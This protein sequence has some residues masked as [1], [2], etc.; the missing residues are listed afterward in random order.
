M[1]MKLAEHRLKNLNESTYHGDMMRQVYDKYRQPAPASVIQAIVNFLTV[2]LRSFAGYKED[3]GEDYNE[4]KRSL[5]LIRSKKSSANWFE[6][7]DAMFGYDTEFRELMVEFAEEEL[8]PDLFNTLYND[9]RNA[10]DQITGADIGNYKIDI[11]NL[12]KESVAEEAQDNGP[13]EYVVHYNDPKTRTSGTR[14]V[15]TTQP[16][17]KSD[18]PDAKKFFGKWTGHYSAHE[19]RSDT[20]NRAHD[21]VSQGEKKNEAMMPPSNFA[22]TEKGYKLGSKGQLKGKTKR[23]AKAGDLVGETKVVPVEESI[24]LQMASLINLLEGKR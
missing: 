9:V 10:Q 8:D 18:S 13:Y 14:T 11:G 20:A 6:L 2:R 23:P 4:V 15:K 5:H 21:V 7:A 3:F 16:A 19:K 1:I 24:E 12:N 22:G 17:P